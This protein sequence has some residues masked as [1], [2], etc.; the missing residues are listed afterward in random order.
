MARRN[1]H[2]DLFDRMQKER[3]TI[4]EF[5]GAEKEGISFI[6]GA[7]KEP[8]WC[9]IE[10]TGKMACPNCYKKAME[11]GVAVIDRVTGIQ[12]VA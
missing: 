2:Y 10:G 3:K 12:T 1:R 6:I 11:E 4:C 9:M 5:C 8:D 7:S